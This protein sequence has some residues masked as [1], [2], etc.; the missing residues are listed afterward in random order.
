MS[1][2][3]DVVS[4]GRTNV[5]PTIVALVGNKNTQVAHANNVNIIIQS[6]PAN[7]KPDL[8]TEYYNL[9]VK[10][11]ESFSDGHFIITKD[12][13]L[14]EYMPPEAKA[15]FSSLSIDAISQIRSLP[16]LFASENHGNGRTDDDHQAYFGIVTDIKPQDNGIKIYFRSFSAI[17]QQRLNEMA[18]ELSIQGSKSFN[19]LN[20]TH[21][22]IKRINL[23]EEL[24]KAG[25]G[26]LVPV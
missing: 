11:D 16:S 14:T 3:L 13:A 15:Q 9:F 22:A 12:R 10:G 25:V 7:T 23:I 1:S 8:N 19:E 24:K 26:V 20:R 4:R 5:T 2:V 18:F 17:P 6:A 21:W